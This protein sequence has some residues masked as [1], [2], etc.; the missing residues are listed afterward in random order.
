MLHYPAPLI[1]QPKPP[2]KYTVIWLHGLGANAEDFFSLVPQLQFKNKPHI[3]FIFPNAPEQ[4]V[5]INASMIMPSWYNIYNLN[6]V[7]NINIQD[8]NNSSTYI[9]TLIN[10]EIKNNISHD[11]I[12]LAGFSQG[13]VVA[14]HTALSGMLKQNIKSVL[15]L[16]SYHPNTELLQPAALKK[17]SI[18]FMHG[19]H[20]NTIPIELTKDTCTKIKQL[21]YSLDFTSYAMAHEICLEQIKDIN[22]Y[23]SAQCN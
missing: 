8:L 3:K 5:S 11:N 16:S 17:S 15:A 10:A 7:K 6:H 9:Q 23:F 4:K 19:T 1:I 20:D 12:I 13:G 18:H 21:N 22:N 14:I 2:H